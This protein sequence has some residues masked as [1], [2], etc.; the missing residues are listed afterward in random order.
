MTILITKF[1]PCLSCCQINS[2]KALKNWQYDTT[3]ITDKIILKN[4][5]SNVIILLPA[6][7]I[8]SK[9]HQILLKQIKAASSHCLKPITQILST[10]TH[11]SELV[12]Q[13]LAKI[14]RICH[15]KRWKLR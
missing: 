2:N 8:S 15:N 5:Y 12:P 6:D 9:I 13:I 4:V 7:Y 14:V 3:T 11:L 10:I 1:N